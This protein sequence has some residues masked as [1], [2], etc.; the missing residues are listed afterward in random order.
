MKL[1]FTMAGSPK[2]TTKVTSANAKAG[3]ANAIKYLDG[4]VT[5]KKAIAVLITFEVAAIRVAY[6]STNPTTSLGHSMLPGDVLRLENWKAINTFQHI[7]QNSGV[8]GD[9]M[10]TPEFGGA[11]H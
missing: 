4:T 8:H 1:A 7:S 6:G 9:M 5:G 10:I 3:L 2:S 11:G